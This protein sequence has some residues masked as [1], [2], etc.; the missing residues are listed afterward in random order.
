MVIV[1]LH[2]FT[3]VKITQ[4][5][6]QYGIVCLQIGYSIIVIHDVAFVPFPN[7]LPISKSVN[8]QTFSFLS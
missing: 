1:I 3:G 5:L 7:G 2:N 8:F 6:L 4:F